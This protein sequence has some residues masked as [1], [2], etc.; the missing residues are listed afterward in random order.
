MESLQVLDRARATKIEG[1]LTDADVARVIALAL[2]DVRELVFNHRALSECFASGGGAE[3][4]PEP[5]L[6]RF[7]LSDRHRAPVAKL[8]GGAL[9][10]KATAIADVGIELDHRAERE[11]LHLP[12]W[13]RDRAGA[14]IERE[15]R[16]GKQLALPRLPRL[17]HDRTA[18]AEH[19][20][21]KGAVDVPAVDQQVVN[22]ESSLASQSLN[23]NKVFSR[24]PGSVRQSARVRRPRR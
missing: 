6:K 16:L 4:F 18:P 17:A 15:G 10:A 22:V 13:A 11:A 24:A 21:D 5:L 3:L 9:R 12:V 2:G 8:G 1:V 23:A 20:I 7:V 19:L 14:D